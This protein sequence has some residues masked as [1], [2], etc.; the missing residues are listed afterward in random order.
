MSSSAVRC[1]DRRGLYQYEL[2][3]RCITFS[4]QYQ[5]K[6]CPKLKIVWTGKPNPILL[7]SL[8]PHYW[9]SLIFNMAFKPVCPVLVSQNVCYQSLK[10]GYPQ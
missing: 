10:P 3:Y 4:E 2:A 5:F 7:L 6:V 8:R 9:M 1:Y